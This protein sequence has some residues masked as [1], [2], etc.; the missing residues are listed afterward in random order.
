MRSKIPLYKLLPMSLLMALPITVQGLDYTYSSDGSA[1]T[2]TGYTGTNS[3][4]TI[5][6]M[7]DGQ[8][9]ATIGEYAFNGSGLT[10]VTIPDSVTTFKRGAFNSNYD[11]IN[12]VMPNSVTSIGRNAFAHCS[13][14]TDVIIPDSVTFLDIGAFYDC[15]KLTSAV[16][17]NSVPEIRIGLFNSCDNLSYVSIGN[18]ITNI[19]DG[20]FYNCASLNKITIPDS[21]THIHYK[22]FQYSYQLT[23]VYIEGDAPSLYGSSTFGYAG[24]LIIYRRPDS[25]G[26]GTT[27]G[28]KLV[29]LYITEQLEISANCGVQSNNFTFNITGLRGAPFVLEVCPDLFSD[30]WTPL[31]TSN[32]TELVYTFSDSQ[33]TNY[34]T[35]YYRVHS[36]E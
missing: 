35:R 13:S 26:W 4:I 20:A 7:I 19:D 32:L 14:L 29:S 18:S 31:L 2:I 28:G 36:P 34:P 10:S 9:V 23:S 30:T 11:L 5:P 22:A 3:V 12:I 21:V 6:E 25:T 33:W 17:G 8:P 24:D 16:I 27:F 1:V 15:T